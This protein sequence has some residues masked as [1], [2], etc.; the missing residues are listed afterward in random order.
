MPILA[1]MLLSLFSGLSGFFGL[2]V[3][4]R[5]ALGAA[6]VVAYGV[7]TTA[8]YVTMGTI[9]GGLIS[10]FPEVSPMVS[11]FLWVALPDSILGVVAA[12]IAAD[13]GFAVYRWNVNNLKI[14]S[15]VV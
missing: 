3:S 12:C 13:S 6:A 11:T 7:L 8:L 9:I 1:S 15:A 14:A 5:V 10:A 2:Y 4:S